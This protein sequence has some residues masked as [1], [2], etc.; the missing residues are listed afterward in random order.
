[1]QTNSLRL[2]ETISSGTSPLRVEP[3]KRSYASRVTGGCQ[4]YVF[5]YASEIQSFFF[6]RRGRR[7]RRHQKF[8]MA[9]STEI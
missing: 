8:V 3:T 5:S 1:M 7:R 9:V 2:P 4:E 6:C